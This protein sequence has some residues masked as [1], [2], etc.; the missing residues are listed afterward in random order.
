MLSD[1][2][3][4]SDDISYRYDK[5]ENALKLGVRGHELSIDVAELFDKKI[6]KYVQVIKKGES[7]TW[8]AITFDVDGDPSTSEDEKTIEIRIDDFFKLY[9]SGYGISVDNEL[10]INISKE[11]D[12]QVQAIQGYVNELSGPVGPYIGIIPSLSAA[13]DKID[14]AQTQELFF[15]GLIE[16]DTSDT[17]KRYPTIGAFLSTEIGGIDVPS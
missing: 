11:F 5:S 15:G 3:L 16:L 6:I 14:L 10:R 8:I 7:G 12:D 17:S 1:T 13:I 2:Y 4:I 9:T